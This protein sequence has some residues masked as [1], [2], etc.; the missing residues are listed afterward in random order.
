MVYRKSYKLGGE[1]F[2][3]YVRDLEKYMADRVPEVIFNIFEDVTSTH[4]VCT[5]REFN[6]EILSDSDFVK[7]HALA[8]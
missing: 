2:R 6:Y 4:D 3:N 8:Q 1:R 7:K 5:L